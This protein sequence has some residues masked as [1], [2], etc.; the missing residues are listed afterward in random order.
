[1]KKYINLNKFKKNCFAISKHYLC[2]EININE[3]N[4]AEHNYKNM[5]CVLCE[6]M[7]KD[8]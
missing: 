4:L 7:K 5:Y 1:M 6:N 8:Y 3:V 2:D